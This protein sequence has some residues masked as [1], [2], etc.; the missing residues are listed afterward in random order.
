ME[1]WQKKRAIAMIN[2]GLCLA[3]EAIERAQTRQQRLLGE[4]LYQSFVALEL[5]YKEAKIEPEGR[6]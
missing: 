3:Q 5:L 2:E 6:Y 1:K 4:A